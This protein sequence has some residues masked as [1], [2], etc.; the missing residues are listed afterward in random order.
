MWPVLVS[1]TLSGHPVL[2]P[3]FFP[4]FAWIYSVHYSLYCRPGYRLTNC[5]FTNEP[6]R[7][8]SR[9][10]F[11]NREI[12]EQAFLLFPPPSP[13]RSPFDLPFLLLSLQLSNSTKNTFWWRL[14]DLPWP[15]SYCP[16]LSLKID[17]NFS[18][19]QIGEQ[20]FSRVLT[21]SRNSEYPWPF[22]VLWPEERWRLASRHFRN[23]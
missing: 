20:H 23:T 11:Q 10:V 18:I 22:T 5:Q 21:G 15:L 1:G 14:N 7:E 17:F 8:I 13:P 3:N 16:I 4:D 12:F 6:N 2:D 9:G 19:Y